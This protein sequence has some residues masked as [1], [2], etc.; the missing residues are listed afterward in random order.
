MPPSEV[1]RTCDVIRQEWGVS[2]PVDESGCDACEVYAWWVSN[3]QNSNTVPYTVSHDGQTDTVD[4]DQKSNGT[5]GKWQLLGAYAFDGSGSEYVEVSNANG[6]AAADAVKFV[7]LGGG[8][9]TTTVSYV[10]NDHLGTPQV[11]TDETGTMVWRATYDL[12]GLATTSVNTVELNVRF[13]GQ[14]YDQE[15]GLHYNYFRYYDP[16]TGRYITSD[17]IGLLGG[18]NPY[19]YANANPLRWFDAYGLEAATGT[20][21][22]AGSGVSIPPWARNPAGFAAWASMFSSL[23]GEGSDVVPDNATDKPEQCDNEDKCQE[24]FIECLGTS[25][26]DGVGG[27]FGHNRCMLCRDACVQNSE[28]WPRFAHTGDRCDYWNSK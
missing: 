25:L 1:G 21:P 10:H 9:A 28:T 2:Q 6:R 24:K 3:S 16:S 19:I 5:G 20:L 11:M 12:F 26:N 13:P 17:P 18:I 14:Y 22:R 8:S 23:V 15:T 4:V 7:S 27:N